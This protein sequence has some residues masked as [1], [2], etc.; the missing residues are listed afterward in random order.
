MD[1]T[2]ARRAAEILWEHWRQRTR[3]DAL[4]DSVRPHTRAEGYAIQREVQ[5][6]AGQA[7]AGWKIAAT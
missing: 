4:P 2:T 6:C 5:A 7:L 3:I 1:T